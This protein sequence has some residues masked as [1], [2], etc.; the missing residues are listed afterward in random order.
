MQKQITE[1]QQLFNKKLQK[2]QDEKNWNDLRI[3]F[4]GKKG[5]IT[6]L[7]KEL[8]SFENKKEL[9]QLINEAKQDITNKLETIK[10]EIDQ[11]QRDIKLQASKIDIS[12]NG[13][14]QNLGKQNILLQ[15]QREIE[16]IFQN[17]GFEVA[18]GQEV[19]TDY[20]NFEAL[21]LGIDHPA[22]DMQ[23]TFYIN[24]KLLLR[25]HTSNIQSRVLS[26]NNNQELKIICP[27][28]VYRR[29][30][31]DA[32][33]SHQFM[34]IEGL[35]VVKK[36]GENSASLKD[37]KTILTMFVRKMFDSENL[38]VRLRPSYF[39]FTEPSVEVDITC[40]HCLGKGCSFCKQTGWIEVLGAG[41]IN[42]KVLELAGYNSEQ[43][44][45]Y[46]FGIGVE[47]MTLLKYNITDIRLLYQNANEFIE[48]F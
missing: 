4:I 39:P 22:R 40:S 43:F 33:H 9:G 38:K 45:G 5:L 30:D 48:Q 44:T 14:K 1:L 21:N 47:R 36:V 41:I 32:T 17:L 6:N 20:H 15:T 19:E 2:I 35:A 11:K 3:E 37:L 8:K 12:I 7:M 13:R 18:L 27:G 24:P 28:K 10:Q 29:D 34:Q 25:T 46:A 42:P 26:Q 31:D 16:T 23:D